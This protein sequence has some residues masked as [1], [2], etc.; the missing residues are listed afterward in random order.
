MVSMDVFSHGFALLTSFSN[1]WTSCCRLAICTGELGSAPDLDEEECWLE[2]P[3]DEIVGWL[4][5]PGRMSDGA[6][7][8]AT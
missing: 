1:L 4:K 7:R 6:A 5:P 8:A 3:D 2:E